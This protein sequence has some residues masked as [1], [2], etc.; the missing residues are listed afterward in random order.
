MARILVAT[1]TRLLSFEP[2]GRPGRP[3]LEGRHVRALAPETWTRLWAVVDRRQI[4]R[5]QG[6]GWEPVASLADLAEPATW[7]RSASPT[8]AR[9]L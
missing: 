2:D 9:T 1:P 7:R 5:N 4:W 8:P 6:D 3:E